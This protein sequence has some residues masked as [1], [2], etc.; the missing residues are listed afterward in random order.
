MVPEESPID[1]RD[2]SRL[3]SSSGPLTTDN[4]SRVMNVIEIY[5]TFWITERQSHAADEDKDDGV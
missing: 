1:H 2:Y 3:R 5:N 4:G